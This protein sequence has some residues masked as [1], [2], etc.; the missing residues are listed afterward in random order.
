MKNWCK[1]IELEEDDVLIQR[2]SNEDEEEAVSFSCRLETHNATA[3]MAFEN[4]EEA[5]KAFAT[6]TEQD[7][8]NMLKVLK[9]EI[10]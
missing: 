3:T 2:T 7:C 4:E 8:K 10:L 1:I 9:L 5:D 6:I